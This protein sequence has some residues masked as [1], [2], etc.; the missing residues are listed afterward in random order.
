MQVLHDYGPLGL[1][2]GVGASLLMASAQSAAICTLLLLEHC[3]QL[4]CLLLNFF[5]L[6][7]AVGHQPHV[8][9]CK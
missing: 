2:N 9:V 8:A 1:W 6:F 3:V 4:V 7:S 5:H